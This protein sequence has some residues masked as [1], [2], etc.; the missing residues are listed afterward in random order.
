MI[1]LALC[2][3]L[4]GTW[5]FDLTGAPI[6]PTYS[7]QHSGSDVRVDDMVGDRMFTNSS[8]TYDTT[9]LS[10]LSYRSHASCCGGRWTSSLARAADGS[11]T[12]RS[13]TDGPS[14]IYTEQ[15]RRYTAPPDTVLVAG[16]GYD[17]LPWLLARHP[18]DHF[19]QLRVNPIAWTAM[20]VHAAHVPTPEGVPVGDGALEIVTH[21][22][23]G[24][25]QTSYLWYDPC[26]FVLD[27]EGPR[28]RLIL[29]LPQR[30]P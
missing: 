15:L 1:A 25:Q 17:L 14:G 4:A 19:L 9:T 3:L 10:L 22:A 11:Y 7:V 2:G 29:R 18:H 28:D 21:V 5:T 16:A 23:P 13:E 12:I 24:E 26:T 27:A 8:A 30:A 6:R 20:E